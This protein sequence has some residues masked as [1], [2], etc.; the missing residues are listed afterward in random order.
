MKS[1]CGAFERT[2]SFKTSSVQRPSG[3]CL[4][5]GFLDFQPNGS[6]LETAI[7]KERASAPK[8]G[9]LALTMMFPLFCY[10]ITCLT[11]DEVCNVPG[12][13]FPHLWRSSVESFKLDWLVWFLTSFICITKLFILCPGHHGL[14]H[15]MTAEYMHLAQRI[16]WSLYSLESL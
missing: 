12:P 1:H 4:S 15:T 7:G 2:F 8:S 16:S 14:N 5:G 10:H 3:C 11:L 6:Y 13:L 9:S